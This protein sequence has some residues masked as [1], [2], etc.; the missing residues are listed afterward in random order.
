MK[1]KVR[2]VIPHGD[3]I[4]VARERRRGRDYVTLPGGRP[5]RGETLPRCLVR[6]VSEETGLTVVVGR[7]LYIAEVVG[8]TTL[9][10]LNL[11]FLAESSQEPAPELLVGADEAAK[12]QV[13]PPMLEVLF[14]DLVAGWPDTPRYLGNI[15]VPLSRSPA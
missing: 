1:V 10:E 14:E 4:V 15:Q 9:Q 11:V 12:L 8:G 5:E 2:A 3:R 13:M 7:L 6:E